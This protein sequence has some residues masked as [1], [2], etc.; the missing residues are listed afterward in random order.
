MHIGCEKK[1]W[2]ALKKLLISKGKI[3]LQSRYINDNVLK[4]RKHYSLSYIQ[5]LKNI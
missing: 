5:S 3:E 1:L 2:Y 4:W